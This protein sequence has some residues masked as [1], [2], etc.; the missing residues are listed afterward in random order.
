[1]VLIH[2]RTHFYDYYRSN[3]QTIF[4]IP[5]CAIEFNE[6]RRVTCIG[7]AV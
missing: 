2:K 6:S 4:S 3:V 1:M 7:L 5:H